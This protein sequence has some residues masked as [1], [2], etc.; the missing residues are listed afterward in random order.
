MRKTILIVED[1]KSL[2]D[3]LEKTLANHNFNVMVAE[4]GAEAVEMV[5]K[6]SQT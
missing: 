3:F 5:K 1:D 6:N 2:R 4:D